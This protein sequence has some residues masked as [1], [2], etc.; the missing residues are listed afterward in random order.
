MRKSTSTTKSA[1]PKVAEW[2]R[3]IDDHPDQIRPVHFFFYAEEEADV[4]RLAHELQSLDFKIIQVMRSQNERW[5]C[6]A[7]MDLVPDPPVMDLCTDLLHKVAQDHQVEYDG[8]ETRVD[9]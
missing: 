3:Y 1:H 4:Y 7:E 2:I 6:L 8:W 9:L 5:L